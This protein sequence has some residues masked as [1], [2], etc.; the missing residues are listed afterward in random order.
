LAHTDTVD[1]HRAEEAAIE[2]VMTQFHDAVVAHE[3]AA[4]SSMFLPDANIWLNVFTD[5]AYDRAQ[6]G[7]A[8]HF[9]DPRKQLPR[10]REVRLDDAQ[11]SRSGNTATL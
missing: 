8:K 5:A 4:L 11:V 2:H 10:F 6:A 9:Q 3:G 1:E 7:A